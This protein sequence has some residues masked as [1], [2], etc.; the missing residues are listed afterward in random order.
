MRFQFIYFIQ[1]RKDRNKKFHLDPLGFRSVS[2]PL[3]RI[4]IL[5]Q[6]MD[7]Y[8]VLRREE[9]GEEGRRTE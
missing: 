2:K 5:K 1:I 7:S 8:A 9:G 3:M 6:D 4:Q